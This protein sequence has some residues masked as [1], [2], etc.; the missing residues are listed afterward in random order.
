MAVV[1]NRFQ[2]YIKRKLKLVGTSELGVQN[3]F[4]SIQDVASSQGG[5][6]DTRTFRGGIRDKIVSRAGCA[7]YLRQDLG[8]LKLIRQVKRPRLI[9]SLIL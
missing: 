4:D 9:R 2:K 5:T 8:C 6:R 1:L 7:A 3:R